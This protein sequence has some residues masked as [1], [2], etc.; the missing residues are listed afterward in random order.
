MAKLI[1][2]EQSGL[3][4][5]HAKR[6]IAALERNPF[7]GCCLRVELKGTD[8]QPNYSHVGEVCWKRALTDPRTWK[9]ALS[10][11]TSTPFE[12]FTD[13]FLQ[14]HSAEH[15]ILPDDEQAFAPVIEN[16]RQMAILARDA[17]E[18]GLSKGR[19][20][21]IFFDNEGGPGGEQDK[22]WLWDAR[23]RD[24]SKI[25]NKTM[26]AGWRFMDAIQREYPGVTIVTPFL[27]SNYYLYFQK[28]PR[29]GKPTKLNDSLESLRYPFMSG[30][31]AAAKGDTKIIDA[32]EWGYRGIVGLNKLAQGK[33]L[34]NGSRPTSW[35]DL[36]LKSSMADFEPRLDFGSMSDVVKRRVIAEPVGEPLVESYSERISTRDLIQQ[37]QAHVRLGYGLSIAQTY[38]GRRWCGTDGNLDEAAAS[39]RDNYFT[40]SA[41]ELYVRSA[42]D[43]ADRDGYVWLWDSVVNLMWWNSYPQDDWTIPGQPLSSYWD[44][45]RHTL[46]KGDWPGDCGR[47]RLP[48]AY[49]SAV[50]AAWERHNRR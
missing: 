31:I 15:G 50:R 5:A 41:L 19:V 32:L 21:G 12:R 6:K 16:A 7:D 43:S 14:F 49:V 3:T 18:Q 37:Y 11:L 34:A 45:A 29:D 24:W 13:V 25:A 1:H 23:G 8:K 30:M 44:G 20:K 33:P 46:P 47:Y 2:F 38:G 22:G 40:P 35:Y 36:T 48:D 27:Q 26:E 9:E 39:T 4:T 42:L 28:F 10:D 17:N